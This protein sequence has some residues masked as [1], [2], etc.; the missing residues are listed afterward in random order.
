MSTD[1]TGAGESLAEEMSGRV[2]EGGATIHLLGGGDNALYSDTGADIDTK[3]D[4]SVAVAEAD[5][6]ITTPSDFNGVVE[7]FND[8]ELNFGELSI[9]TVDDIVIQ[10]DANGDLWLLADEP[11]NPELTG[12]E[13]S[14]AAGTT[15]YEFGN[16]V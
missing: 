13:V 2:I 15:I 7:L 11:N 3:S 8:N 12:E 9:G 10:N 1:T 14:I 4:A 5:W 6:T 16:P